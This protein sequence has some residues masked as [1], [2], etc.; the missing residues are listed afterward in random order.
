LTWANNGGTLRPMVLPPRS[1][2]PPILLSHAQSNLMFCVRDWHG[3][4][5]SVRQV[6]VIIER[7]ITKN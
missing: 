3:A 1:G 6:G 5:K 2:G 7:V 4:R